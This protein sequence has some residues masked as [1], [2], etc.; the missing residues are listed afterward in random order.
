MN[1]IFV[2]CYLHAFIVSMW[3]NQDRLAYL[4]FSQCSWILTG[5]WVRAHNYKCWS[6]PSNIFIRKKYPPLQCRKWHLCLITCETVWLIQS[7][8]HIATLPWPI[9][10][11][12]FAKKQCVRCMLHAFVLKKIY[13]WFMKCMSSYVLYVFLMHWWLVPV[14]HLLCFS[15]RLSFCLKQNQN[16][17]LNSHLNVYIFCHMYP[18]S[19]SFETLLCDTHVEQSKQIQWMHLCAL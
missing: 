5:K 4:Q 12:P 18:W 8:F 11:C 15:F 13:K 19:S 14:Q 1:N 9:N 3:R 6:E 10:N 16:A 17:K 7:M 2:I